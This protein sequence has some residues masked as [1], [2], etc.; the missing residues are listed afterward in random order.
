MTALV[1]INAQKLHLG[2]L[3][4]VPVI[5]YVR[6]LFL[7]WADTARPKQAT[8]LV[9]PPVRALVAQVLLV[10]AQPADAGVS[11]ESAAGWHRVL[12]EVTTLCSFRRDRDHVLQLSVSACRK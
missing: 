4:L 9:Q 10:T 7:S 11:H 2:A 3:A 5:L 1:S 8:F 6:V 12:R